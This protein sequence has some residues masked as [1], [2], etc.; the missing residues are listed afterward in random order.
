MYCIAISGVRN[1]GGTYLGGSGSGSLMRRQSEWE[2][3]FASHTPDKGFI[4]KIYK[5]AIQLSSKNQRIQFLN[6]QMI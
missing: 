2:N 4:D 1:P 3:I 6:G 5:E